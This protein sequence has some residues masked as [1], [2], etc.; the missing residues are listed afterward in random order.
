MCGVTGF[1]RPGGLP[2]SRRMSSSRMTSSLSHRGP[3]ETGQ[4][5]DFE[6]GI[7]LGHRRLS[8]LELSAAGS[9]PMTSHSGRYVLVTNGEI[10]N[11]LEIREALARDGGVPAWRGHSD[12]ESL[13]AAFDHWGVETA[14]RKSVGMFALAVWD[15]EERTLTLRAIVSERSRCITACRATSALWLGAEIASRRTRH[16]GPRSIESSLGF[17]C[18]AVMCQRRCPSTWA[19]ASCR[20]AASFA[21]ARARCLADPRNRRPTG[22]STKSRHAGC[23]VPSTAAMTKP[24]GNWRRSSPAPSRPKASPTFR[25]APSSQAAS[26][27]PRSLH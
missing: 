22:R 27:R 6:A 13:L 23:R 14:L 21:S 3:D 24:S 1:F 15:R 11:H 18:I 20:P 17:T 16:S 19:S 9:Q 2:P 4:W 12:T 7:A 26:T 8:I 25:S 10:Y 5:F